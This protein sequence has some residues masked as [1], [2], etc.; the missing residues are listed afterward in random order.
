MMLACDARTLQATHNATN[1]S[2]SKHLFAQEIRQIQPDLIRIERMPFL[3][4]CAVLSTIVSRLRAVVAAAERRKA[5]H[6]GL[7][8]TLRHCTQLRT[9]GLQKGQRGTTS[10]PLTCLIARRWTC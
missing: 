10:E 6:T 8:L 7:L 3:V 4:G 2:P 5:V 1:A 9:S